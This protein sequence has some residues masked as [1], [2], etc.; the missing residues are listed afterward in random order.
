MFPE[1]QHAV[2]IQQI[3]LEPVDHL[4]HTAQP[5]VPELF[6]PGIPRI[7]VFTCTVLLVRV[8]EVL[9]CGIVAV[10]GHSGVGSCLIASFVHPP[11][12]ERSTQMLAQSEIHTVFVRRG[13]PQGQDILVGAHV[14]AVHPV[15][16]GIIVEKVVMVDRLGHQVPGA[17][18]MI[19]CD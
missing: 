18:L 13:L 5:V 6:V 14:H 3:R 10:I 12:G 19:L 16:F 9:I 4:V 11:P 17:G 7:Q 8:I 2:G 1:G 15:D